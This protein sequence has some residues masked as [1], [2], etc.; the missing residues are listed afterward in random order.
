MFLRFLKYNETIDLRNKWIYIAFL[1]NALVRI[2]QM[3]CNKIILKRNLQSRFIFISF[4]FILF[5]ADEA[6]FIMAVKTSYRQYHSFRFSILT[7]L[8]MLI[9]S[10]IYSVLF[11]IRALKARNLIKVII[12]FIPGTISLIFIKIAFGFCYGSSLAI[13]FVIEDLAFTIFKALLLPDRY[14]VMKKKID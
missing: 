9:T 14:K 11:G 7:P 6:S 2:A 5:I 12:D 10:I 8:I 4:Y 1:V 13:F 3:I